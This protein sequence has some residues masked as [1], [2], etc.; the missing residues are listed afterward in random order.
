MGL[1]LFQ[2]IKFSILLIFFIFVDRHERLGL[3]QLRCLA[4]TKLTWLKEDE[5]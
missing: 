2:I 1:I 4:L 5:L 3:R